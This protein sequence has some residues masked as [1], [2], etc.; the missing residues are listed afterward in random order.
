MAKGG[1]ALLLVATADIGSVVKSAMTIKEDAVIPLAESADARNQASDSS[2]VA[3]S[4]RSST[5][6]IPFDLRE[7]S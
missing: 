3:R 5:G 7:A 1:V 4:Q 6:R 2:W